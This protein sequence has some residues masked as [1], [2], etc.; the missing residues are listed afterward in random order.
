MK[1]PQHSDASCVAHAT[2]IINRVLAKLPTMQATRHTFITHILALML[3]VRGRCTFAT[4]ARYGWY[5][6]RSYRYRFEQS[7]D[8]CTFNEMLIKEHAGTRRIVVLDPSYIPKSRNKTPHVGTF[9]SGCAGKPLHG[10]EITGLA[11]VDLDHNTALHLEA[12]QTPSV[13]ELHREGKTL[14]EHYAQVVVD[15]KDTLRAVAKYLVVDG[16]FGKRLFFDHVL[17]RTDLA[18]ICKLRHDADLRYLYRGPQRVGKGRPKVFDGKVD[19]SNLA[20]SR[21]H[22]T[23]TT[24]G[25]RLLSATVYAPSL[26]RTLMVVVVREVR[27]D[28]VVKDRAVL[29]SSDTTLTAGTLFE[30]YRA[31]FH[32]EFLFRDA[33][34]HAGLTHC[35]ARSERKLHFHFNASLTAVSVA[36][37]AHFWDTDGST[38]PTYSLADVGMAY[39]NDFY[40]RMILSR[41]DITPNHEKITSA[42][43]DLLSFG[44]IHGR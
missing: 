33:K 36:K 19:W 5:H 40:L 11:T 14:T 29:C 3:T 27:E 35:Q 10:L 18:L 25:V 24:E 39:F 30:Y 15:R 17:N 7:F 16:Y 2:T 41:L 32:I 8:W 28:G 34:Q 44:L 13:A 42:V 22:V 23:E 38:S 37:V 43:S 12:V 4:F 26:K 9:W 20:T 21:W 31:R 1:S 6:E